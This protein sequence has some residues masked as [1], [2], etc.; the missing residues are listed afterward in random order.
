MRFIS[1]LKKLKKGKNILLRAD[2][3]V[4]RERRTGRILS[5]YRI[6]ETLPTI[7][8]CLKKKARVLLCSHFGRPGG[9]KDPR[10]SLRFLQKRIQKLTGVTV[11]FVGDCVGPKVRWALE[12][13]IAPG[14]I[15]LLENLRFYKQE[16]KNDPDFSKELADLADY[17]VNDAFGVCHRS[18]ASVE[19]ITKFKRPYTGFLIQKEIKTL[20]KI[21]NQPKAPFILMI[22]GAKITDKIEI[23][24]SL[25]K[26]ADHILIGGALANTFLKAKGM[27]LGAS[28]FE[29]MELNLALEI[30]RKFCE[31]IILPNDGQVARELRDGYSKE[32]RVTDLRDI[33]KK[34]AVLDI[35]PKTI[36]RFSGM[37]EKAKTVF[38]AGP[39]GYFEKPP[40]HKGSV[41]VI[42]AMAFSEAFCVAGG[43]ETVTILEKSGYFDKMDHVSTGGGA[44]LAFVSGKTLPG[45]KALGYK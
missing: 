35:G 15:L 26:K 9:T 43:G 39:M 45:L 22:G 1:Q 3:N 23:I 29:P 40:F 17:Y 2:L 36:V 30:T 6:R 27:N 32:S 25:G 31:K 21:K 44:S 28:L 38:F 5:D 14:G 33:K 7:E 12:K 16:K 24:E 18:H 42:R 34:E 19:G 10:F 13:K 11:S 41:G 20:S 4:S 37:V 8:Y